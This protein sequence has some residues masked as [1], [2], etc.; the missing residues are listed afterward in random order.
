[1]ATDLMSIAQFLDNRGWKYRID[2]SQSRIVTGVQVENVENF[3]IVISVLEDGEFVKMYTPQLLQIKDHRFKG[4]VFQTLLNIAWQVKMLRY[5]YDVTDGEVRAAIELPLED[6]PLTE[7]QFNRCLSGLIDLVDR[8]SMPRIQAV[9][10]N[11][12]DPG[13]KS[14]PQR[15]LEELSDEQLDL[16]EQV[17]RLR[18]HVQ[19]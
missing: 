12:E 5:Q 17:V 2:S 18:R 7:R 8:V 19:H 11:G 9:L 6:A 4:V 1:M 3:V 14:I 16:L 10:S 15:M 13:D